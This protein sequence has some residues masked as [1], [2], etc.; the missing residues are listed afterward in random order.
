MNLKTKHILA[1]S[2]VAGIA[3]LIGYF[4]GNKVAQKKDQ[5]DEVSIN[6][7]NEYEFFE[8]EDG[9]GIRKKISNSQE[10][11]ASES[12]DIFIAKRAYGRIEEHRAWKDALLDKQ[13]SYIKDYISNEEQDEED[14]NEDVENLQTQGETEYTS[15]EPYIVEESDVFTEQTNPDDVE[16][17]SFYQT[18]DVLVDSFDEIIMERSKILGDDVIE[19][20]RSGHGGDVVYVRNPITKRDYEVIIESGSYEIDVLGA[21]EE[22]YQNAVKFF[23]LS[24]E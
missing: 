1:V 11:E 15:D 3:G 10:N 17:L 21:D 20:L 19:R 9:C 14:E 6:D 16:T 23:K 7:A 4:I 18:D 12:D 2:A 24:D 5:E 13:K 22:Q 8:T